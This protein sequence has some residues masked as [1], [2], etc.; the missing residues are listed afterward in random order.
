M[1]SCTECH[2]EDDHAAIREIS[3]QDAGKHRAWLDK[4]K[5]E[6]GYADLY[7]ITDTGEVV[8]TTAKRSDLGENVA[9]GALKDSPL[10]R[11]F[12][13]AMASAVF[14]DFA[15]YPPADFEPCAFI[16]APVK[17]DN[18]M[19]GVL[20]VQIARDMINEIT[21]ERT[22][23]GETGQTYLVGPDKLMR[24]DSFLDPTNHSVVASFKNPSKGSVDTESST[25]ALGG[26][27][28][29][30]VII[31]YNSD[32]VLS[33]WTPV[34]AGATTWGLLAE[35]DKSEAMGAI[36]DMNATA[37]AATRTL[38]MWAGTLG[39]VAA[40][41][42]TLISVFITGGITKPLNRIIVG[43][44]EGADQVNDA[45][46][47]MSSASQQLAEGASEQVSSLEETSSAL[48]EMAARTRTNA[49]NA[50]EANDLS[51]QA[52]RA[53]NQ[54]NQ[55]MGKLNEAM[56]GIN[57][58]SGK[59]SKI[60]KVI[61]EIAFQTNLLALNA[62]VEAARAGE[63]GK[64]FAVVA[65]E[66]RNLA[67]RSAQAARETTDLI[68][69]AVNRAK[70]GTDVAC[71]VG[72]ALGAIVGDVTKVTDLIDRI[73]RAS[74]EQAQGVDQVNSAVSQIDKVTQQSAA[75][76]EESASAAKELSAHAQSVKG[77][78]D[79]LSALMSGAHSNGLVGVE[80][81]SP[82]DKA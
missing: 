1:A 45:A 65:D 64:G 42:V 47:Q 41:L 73:T 32:P 52:S 55:T 82:R 46:N 19:M 63:H 68:E 67:Q 77:V 50:K 48:E 81:R 62:A 34:N 4:Y 61:E 44:N 24:S 21:L 6:C 36:A 25:A 60:I 3:E 12:E 71:E 51:G 27:T 76:A 72:R 7:L 15:P 80:Q 59:I 58:S 38:V 69:G 8:H 23:M 9:E 56:A 43:L 35:I 26:D 10:G 39:I 79:E 33:A 78:V 31:N 17:E 22:G 49:E 2:D 40:V 29:A 57:D 16:G 14:E 28:N 11:C 66:V 37:T 13:K 53:A 18:A 54:G 74:E 70:E 20:V 75:G 5:E 30:K